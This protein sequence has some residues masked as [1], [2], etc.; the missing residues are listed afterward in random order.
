M[1]ASQPGYFSLQ[2]FSDAGL[3]LA[4]GRLYTYA[5]GTTTF[6]AAYTDADGS[7]PQT[8]TSDGIG[9]QYIAL[10]A[11]GELPA[12]LYL[13]PGSYDITLR[14]PDGSTVWTRRADPLDDTADALNAALLAQLA[15][16]SDPAKGAGLSGWSPSTEY[17][18]GTLGAAQRSDSVNIW[19][20]LTDAELAQVKAGTTGL[21]L[22]GKIATA[23]VFAGN[24]PIY[25][26][27]GTYSFTGIA[28]QGWYGG[29]IGDGMDQTI[30]K[31]RSGVTNALDFIESSDAIVSPFMLRDFHLDGNSLAVNGINLQYRHHSLIENVYITGC[32]GWGVIEKDAWL[33]R[34]RNVRLTGNTNGWWLVGSNHASHLDGCVVTGCSGTHVLIESNG[35]AAD[36]NSA[37][38]LSNCTVTDGTGA[39]LDIACSDVTLDCCYIGENID[40]YVLIP[41]GGIITLTGGTAFFGHTTNSYLIAPVG[42]RTIISGA[43]VSGQTYGST[44]YLCSS[45]TGGVWSL[46]DCQSAIFVSGDRVLLEN[47][48]DYGPPGI[49]FAHRLGRAMTGSGN[50]ATVTPVV[51]GNQLTVACATAPGPTPNMTITN[52]L[53]QTRPEW[54]EGEPLYLV[55]VYQSN[56][57]FNVRLSGGALGGAPTQIVG[58]MPATGGQTR[59]YVKLDAAVPAGNFDRVEFYRDGV[60]V[61]ES[62][63]MVECFVADSRMLAKGAGVLG[64]LYKC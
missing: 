12:P 7:V 38:L 23:R 60:A 18:Q 35:T 11:R 21:D 32:S 19:W 2:E 40:S 8:Y 14:R 6:K 41:R 26:P 10:N 29:I 31:V 3:L 50:N 59:T 20:F 52:M 22:T 48:L 55:V 4:S 47:T 51:F 36:G 63:T 17:L 61:G 28:G 13:A 43:Q 62:L 64:N 42:G 1:A 30:L 56:A 33:S 9:G 34:R 44:D 49:V 45:H 37:L 5:Q 57:A 53:D 15:N 27:A 39:G 46:R 16:A 58:V 24:R 25:F 54:R